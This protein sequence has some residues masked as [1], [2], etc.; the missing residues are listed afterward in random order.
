MHEDNYTFR[1]F[2][3]SQKQTLMFQ[4]FLKYPYHTIVESCIDQEH[5]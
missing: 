5:I 2:C 4:H 1:D 3:N